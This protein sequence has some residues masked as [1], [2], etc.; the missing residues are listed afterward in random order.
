MVG[1]GRA[2]AVYEDTGETSSVYERAAFDALRE[3]GADRLL[4]IGAAGFNLPRDG[5][6]V[7]S[8][9]VIDAVDVDPAMKT[10]AEREF[11]RRPL[12]AKIRFLPLSA[13]YAAR[14]L[15]RDGRHYG[16]TFLDAY[17]GQGIPDELVT[18]EFF[19]DVRELSDRTVANVV[20]DRDLD[21]AFSQNLLATFRAA[22]GAAWTTEVEPGDSYLTNIL[23]SSWPLKGAVEWTGKGTIY[24]DDRNSAARDHV[25]M[26]W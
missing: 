8:V 25:A 5:A 14:K 12:P 2:S 22:F 23:V 16:F 11:L 6:T 1:G 24:R 3:S 15:H 4:V 18:L 7:P 26:R 17:F 19:R 10:I 13:R 21:S 20:T 9:N